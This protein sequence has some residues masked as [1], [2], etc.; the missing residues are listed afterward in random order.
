MKIGDKVRFLND[1]GGGVVT[2]F[3]GK[4]VVLVTDEDGF[5]VPTLV[6]D[7][8]VIETDNYNIPKKE[9]KPKKKALP[10]AAPDAEEEPE[11]ADLADLPLNYKP[12]PR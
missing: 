10:E 3:Q 8:V 5:E 7:V 12:L 11:E 4:D 2:G 9:L 6:K 1:V